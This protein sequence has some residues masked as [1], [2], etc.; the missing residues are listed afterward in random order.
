MAEIENPGVLP[1]GAPEAEVDES[2]PRSFAVLLPDQ[3][4]DLDYRVGSFSLDPISGESTAVIVVASFDSRLVVAFPGV[5]WHRNTAPRKIAKRAF[6]RPL[7]CSVLSCTLEDRIA[8]GEGDGM[9]IWVGILHPDFE[10]LLS[11]Q[12]DEIPEHQFGTTADGAVLIPTAQA[13]VDI[14][15]EHYAPPHFVSAMSQGEGQPDAPE[16]RIAK[17]EETMQSIQASLAA[18]AGDRLVQPRP[19]K[20]PSAAAPPRPSALKTPKYRGL[21]EST[22]AAALQAGIP[23]AHLEELAGVVSTKPVRLEDLPRKK[24]TAKADPLDESEEEAEE[25][26]ADNGGLVET[27]ARPMTPEAEVSQALAKLTK[28]CSSLVDGKKRTDGLEALLEGS[29]LASSSDSSS[30]PA[31]R[32]NAAAL[33]GLQKALRENP[34]LIYEAIESNL[35]ADFQSR[36]VSHGEPLG[37]GTVR[38]WLCS[39]SRIQQYTNQIRWTWAVSGIWDCLISGRTAEA[40]ARCSLL[41]GASDQSSIDG[42]N[43]LLANVALLEPSA[44]YHLFAHHQA[45]GVHDPQH[46]ALFDSR[47][48]EVF[49][50]HVRELDQY[51]EARRKLGRPGK[52]PDK[53]GDG[54]A[55]AKAAAKAKAKAK[56]KG[57]QSQ[58]GESGEADA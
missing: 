38:A 7:S 23:P 11:F 25:E 47:W 42:G 56:Q 26:E 51:Q 50:S 39:R 30:I 6:I 53:D 40:R 14:A 29:G 3:T 52:V 20:A 16:D 4:I 34:K 31:S 19:K 18:L 48:V 37:Q 24:P 32:R 58:A 10:S 17:L 1:D 43:W 9:K 8:A 12:E 45:P 36:P 33:R 57:R 27:G 15:L 21:D 28:I 55:A 41:V 13:L 44:P 46:S 54:G 35:V 22:V 2:D 49:M 5:V